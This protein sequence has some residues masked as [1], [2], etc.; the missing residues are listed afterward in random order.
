M[1]NHKEIFLIS[2]D[3]YLAW[4]AIHFDKSPD[5]VINYWKEIQKRTQNGNLSSSLITAMSVFSIFYPDVSINTVCGG[6]KTTLVRHVKF[7]ESLV[8]DDKKKKQEA[9][10]VSV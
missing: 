5:P 2:T 1:S 7:L 6:S 4:L 8:D 10:N 9:S 3:M